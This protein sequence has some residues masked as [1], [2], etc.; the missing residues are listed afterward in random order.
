[1]PANTGPA[2]NIV[3]VTH[4]LPKPDPSTVNFTFRWTAPST[5]SSN[6]VLVVGSNSANG[7]GQ[8]TGDLITKKTFT[9]TPGQSCSYSMSPTSQTFPS[10]GGTASITMTTASGCAWTATSSA[11]FI[12]FTAA[13]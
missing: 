12:T 9:A 10:A 8:E 5:A 1:M 4:S 3:Y 7:N 13:S 2:G 6:A 11:G